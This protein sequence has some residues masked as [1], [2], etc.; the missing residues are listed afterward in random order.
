MQWYVMQVLYSGLNPDEKRSD[1]HCR[2][3]FCSIWRL[4]PY[5]HGNVLFSPGNLGLSIAASMQPRLV[6]GAELVGHRRS[7]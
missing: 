4:V 6:T 7:G 5:G 1:L 3:Q 2:D